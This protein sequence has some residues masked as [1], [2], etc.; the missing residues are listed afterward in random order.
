M[1]QQYYY[2]NLWFPT[3]LYLKVKS[4]IPN[5]YPSYNFILLLFILLL[6]FKTALLFILRLPVKFM[7]VPDNVDKHVV[8]FDNIVLPLTFKDDK[9]VEAPWRVDAPE[10]FND[11]THVVTFD[12]VVTPETFN[13]DTHVELYHW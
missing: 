2:K 4:L 8:T 9:W 3:A 7:V 10:T 6:K 13:D 1:F 12:N 5:P 11:D